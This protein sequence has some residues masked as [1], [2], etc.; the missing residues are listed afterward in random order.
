MV[1]DKVVVGP[2]AKPVAF[3]LALLPDTRRQPDR[4]RAQY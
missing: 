3:K 2:G 1:Q 4:E